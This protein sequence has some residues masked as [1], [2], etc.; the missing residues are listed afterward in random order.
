MDSDQVRLLAYT[1]KDRPFVAP[2]ALQAPRAT[3]GQDVAQIEVVLLGPSG[4]RYTRRIDVPGVCLEHPPDAAPHIQGDTIRVHRDTVLVEV[5]EINGFDRIEAAIYAGSPQAP[6]RRVLASAPLDVAH[7][8]PAGEKVRYE[9][10][11]F[12]SVSTPGPPIT[13]DTTGDVLWPESF[14]DPDVYTIY[15]DPAEVPWR[16]NITIV[17][18]GYT[19]AQKATMVSHANALVAYLRSKTPYKEHDP[20]INYILVYAYSGESGTD[21]CDCGIVRN[22][23]MSTGFP[24]AGYPCGDGGNR[25]LYYGYS[26][27]TD[28]SFHLAQAEARAPASDA[29]MVMVNTARYGG[30]GGQ[31]AVYS[32]GNA[33]ATD[34]EAHELGH[35]LAGLADEY[36]TFFGCGSVA[37]GINT[38]T[39]ATE[40]DWPEWIPDLGPPWEGAQYYT[41]CIYRPQADC[42]MRSLGSEF[43]NVCRQRWALTIFGHSRVASTSPVKF[44]SP[45]SPLLVSPGT[46]EDFSITTRFA[47]GPSVTNSI[48]WRIQGPGFPAPTTVATGTASYSHT[49]TAI[50]SYTLTCEVVADTNFVKPSKN[51]AN[52]DVITWR[53]DAVVDADGDGYL[54]NVDCNDADPAIHPDATESCNG[55]DD[56]CNSGVDEGFDQDRDGVTTCGG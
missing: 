9:D 10:L 30:C 49:F 7:F 23:A 28:T 45:S 41:S 16:I 48:T 15:G 37:G 2:L 54:S 46:Q 36:T 3:R 5:P 47:T 50:G 6:V 1:R 56:N 38:S 19:Y 33:F 11:A 4:L 52:M 31:R 22:T 43:C 26:C 35:S 55:V 27:D 20:F 32:A 39:N 51:A 17:P 18:D 44:M 13:P 34:V 25:C 8:T 42:S 12:A 14:G 29:K 21:Q 24:N 40:G 53:I